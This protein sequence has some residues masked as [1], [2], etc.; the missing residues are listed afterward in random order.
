MAQSDKVQI[1]VAH[2][3]TVGSNFSNVKA[4][5]DGVENGMTS[6]SGVDDVHSARMSGA[7]ESF[8]YEWKTSRRTLL[9]NVGGLSDASSQIA[10]F[11]SEF[12]VQM[13]YSLGEFAS[14]LRGGDE[15]SSSSGERM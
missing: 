15:G 10:S 4:E 7:A 8:F 14:K 1:P 11:T 9:D 12:D 5:L 13:A 2:L 3:F 6:L